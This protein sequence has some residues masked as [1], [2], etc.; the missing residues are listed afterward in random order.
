[1]AEKI[2]AWGPDGRPLHRMQPSTGSLPTIH[3]DF[4]TDGMIQLS[5]F[6]RSGPTKGK[7]FY[8]V[9]TKEYA[10]V[11]LST[12]Y[13]LAGTDQEEFFRQLES[14]FDW[15]WTDESPGDKLKSLSLDD[16]F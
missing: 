16:L 2:K 1:M 9:S 3:V 14:D 6:V 13:W 15:E 12:L 10:L 4:T 5:I 8:R 7:W 11:L